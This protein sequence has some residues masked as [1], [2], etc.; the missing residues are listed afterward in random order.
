MVADGLTKLLP[1]QK[2][3]TFIKQLGL[4]DLEDLIGE[5]WFEEEEI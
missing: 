2:Y 4:I 1:A 5:L 3:Q